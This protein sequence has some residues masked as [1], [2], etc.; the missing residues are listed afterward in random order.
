MRRCSSLSCSG[1]ITVDG[2]VSSITHAPPLMVCSVAVV[3][4]CVLCPLPVARCP[5]PVARCPWPV[6]RWP[7]AGGLL[8]FAVL[9]EPLKHARGAHAAADAHR[10]EAIAAA[11]SLHL[12]NQSGR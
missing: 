3:M 5:L 7:V 11:A 1:V 4:L 6:G 12:V 2:S 8:P 10:D 9:S